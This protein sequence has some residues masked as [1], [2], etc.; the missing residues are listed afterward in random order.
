MK[1]KTDHIIKDFFKD[2]TRFSDLMNAILYD[3]QDVI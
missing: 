1:M 2:T 3:G